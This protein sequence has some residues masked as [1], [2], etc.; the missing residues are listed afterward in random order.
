MLSKIG[1]RKGNENEIRS[2]NRGWDNN[3]LP[4]PVDY[5][6]IIVVSRWEWGQE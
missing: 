2:R 3:Y 4:A 5:S 1:T 6:C